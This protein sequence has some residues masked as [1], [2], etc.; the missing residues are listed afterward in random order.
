MDLIFLYGP[1]AVGKLTIGREL[2][3]MTG[4]RLFHNHLVVD[5]LT[6]VFDFG[7]EPFVR[8]REEIWISVFREAARQGTSLIF[9]FS[10]ERTVSESFVRDA[11][12]AVEKEGG[13]MR[14]VALT[15]P[16]AEL[17]K[18]VEN[19]SRGTFGKLRSLEL[20]RELA[21]TGAFQYP[22]HLQPEL[23]IDTSEIEPAEAAFRICRFFDLPAHR[24]PV[25]LR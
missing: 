1:A 13:R 9:T 14:F 16:L 8:L 2:S 22:G 12:G 19:E 18:R 17:E 25:N 21:S 10:P 23:T 3:Q 4:F 15:C 24:G 7:S 20:F 11:A 5:A 6:A